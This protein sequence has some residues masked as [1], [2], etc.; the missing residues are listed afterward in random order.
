MGSN[1]SKSSGSEGLAP[2]SAHHAHQRIKDLVDLG[3]VLPN[4]IYPTAQQDYDLR[5]VR[6]LI[7]GRKL[8]PFY[9]GLPDPPDPVHPV[10]PVARTTLLEP[11]SPVGSSSMTTLAPSPGKHGTTTTPTTRPRSASSSGVVGTNARTT[12]LP[13]S[14]Q[15][16][17]QNPLAERQIRL[18]RMR[19]REQMLYNDAVECPIC[20][21]VSSVCMAKEV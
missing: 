7:L 12:P 10:T 13:R 21:L 15:H 3:S 8:A 9:K 4:G 11:P 19:L 6:I 5:V 18:E 1:T 2:H 20:F 16:P 17:G 14:T